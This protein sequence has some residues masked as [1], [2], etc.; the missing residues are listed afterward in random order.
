MVLLEGENHRPL[1]SQCRN[2]L[3]IEVPLKCSRFPVS[4]L[5]LVNSRLWCLVTKVT[6]PD[7]S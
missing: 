6:H 1:L 4:Y 5:D 2:N 3:M 7:S